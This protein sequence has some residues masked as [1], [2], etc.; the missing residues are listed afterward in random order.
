[1]SLVYRVIFNLL[2]HVHYVNNNHFS[3]R[4][5][6]KGT[7]LLDKS[8]NSQLQNFVDEHAGNIAKGLVEKGIYCKGYNAQLLLF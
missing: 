8:S 4:R 7:D 3:K 6:R 1:M 5:A 2:Y